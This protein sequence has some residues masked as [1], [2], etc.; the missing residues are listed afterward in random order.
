MA[1]LRVVEQTTTTIHL[2]VKTS[3][4]TVK[5]MA[6]LGW[7]PDGKQLSFD[8]AHIDGAGPGEIELTGL[9]EAKRALA[10][11]GRQQGAEVVVFRGARRTS[12]RYLG[13]T[14][15]P[16]YFPCA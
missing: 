16:I 12:G 8:K 1:S 9:N 14:P 6:D 3:K 13:K 7:S 2:E 10:E 15:K 5:I 4:G 11:F